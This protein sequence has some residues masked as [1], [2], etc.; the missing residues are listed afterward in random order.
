MSCGV[1]RR[2]GS[3]PA[4]LWLWHRPAATAP[5]Q[6]LA[7]EPPYA[8]GAALEKAKRQ[9]KEKKEKE[10]KEGINFAGID[11]GKVSVVL[12]SEVLTKTS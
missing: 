10:K 1:G 7:W 12:M 4:L 6:P 9:K 3:D 5:I 2:R 8:A 11:S